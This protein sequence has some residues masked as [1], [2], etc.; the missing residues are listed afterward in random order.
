MIQY[1]SVKIIGLIS[2]RCGLVPT[3]VCIS[4]H[5]GDGYIV[6]Y[7]NT[8]W[9]KKMLHFSYYWNFRCCN[10]SAIVMLLFLIMTILSVMPFNVW[11]EEFYI[12]TDQEGTMVVSNM[13]PQENINFNTWSSNSYQNSTLTDKDDTIV[14]TNIHKERI[15]SNIRRSNSY[16]D[17]TSE[18]R[19]HW[20]RDNAL[21]DE[22]KGKNGHRKKVKDNVGMDAG[23]YDVNIKK[24]A[25][26]LYQDTYTLIIIKTRDCVELAGRDGSLLDWSGI[27][28]DLFFKNTNK[29]CMVRKV[30]K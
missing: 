5:D 15:N 28:G 20:G 9:T 11:G 3:C 10:F 4:K 16:H 17:S 14:I 21:I 27:S 1:L 26:N 22:R 19:L 13:P 23:M 6:K 30:Y 2:N 25:N 18:E 29:T 12:H 7:Y 24:I 8:V